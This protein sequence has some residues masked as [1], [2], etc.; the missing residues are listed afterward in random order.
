MHVTLIQMNSRPGAREENVERAAAFVDE[1]ARQ[2]AE[3][4]VLPVSR[5]LECYRGIHRRAI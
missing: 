3:L 5:R 2:G 1:A 4:V